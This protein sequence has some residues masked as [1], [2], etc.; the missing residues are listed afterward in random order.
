MKAGIVIDKTRNNFKALVEIP[1]KNQFYPSYPNN[2]EYW[3][4]RKATNNELYSALFAIGVRLIPERYEEYINMIAE[5]FYKE[6]CQ[7][8]YLIY[9]EVENSGFYVDVNN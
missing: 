8:T 5:K 7:N 3:D 9:D 1:G 6:L 2:K 4:V